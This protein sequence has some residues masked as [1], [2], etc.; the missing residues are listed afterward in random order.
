MV[1]A[2]DLLIVEPEQG[3]L[4]EP[5]R[6]HPGRDGPGPLWRT[7]VRSPKVVSTSRSAPRWP[8]TWARRW[9]R[10]WR[11]AFRRL[12]DVSATVLQS[13]LR[14]DADGLVA[15]VP[16]PEVGGAGTPFRTALTH[17]SEGAK[18]ETEISAC[19]LPRFLQLL[20]GLSQLEGQGFPGCL[21][22][23]LLPHESDEV[24]LHLCRL[25]VSCS[26]GPGRAGMD[27]G[28]YADVVSW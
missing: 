28:G 10:T 19:S 16:D 7:R 6:V 27:I 25:L 22:R 5:V 24:L 4:Q 14:V 21:V 9:V 15:V 8:L 1:E 13:V 2:D 26:R 20:G 18:N 3:L 17:G 11:A 23:S 12:A